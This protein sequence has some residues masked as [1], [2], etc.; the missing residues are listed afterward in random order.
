MSFGKQRLLELL[1]LQRN[2]VYHEGRWYRVD[3]QDGKVWCDGELIDDSWTSQDREIGDLIED[4]IEDRF[5][6]LDL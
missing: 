3:T 1:S 2:W 6:I 5:E 4:P